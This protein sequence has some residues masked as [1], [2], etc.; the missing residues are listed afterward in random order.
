MTYTASSGTLNPT[1]PYHTAN[2]KS[3]LVRAWW[4]LQSCWKLVTCWSQLCGIHRLSVVLNLLSYRPNL[5]QLLCRRKKTIII[6]WQVTEKYTCFMTRRLSL[7]LCHLMLCKSTST[8]SY[9]HD[10]HLSEN[11]YF[12][13][14]SLLMQYL[15]SI[16][17]SIFT[18]FQWL[19]QIYK[20]VPTKVYP[21]QKY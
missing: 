20:N 10:V 4:Q 14:Y 1:I 13:T 3:Y 2:R 18:Y 9:R 19:L 6:C 21:L 11:C 7:Q 12:S 5:Q 15:Q 8:M 17:L 16:L